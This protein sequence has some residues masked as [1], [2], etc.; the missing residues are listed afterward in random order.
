MSAEDVTPLVM[1]SPTPD[2]GW[3]ADDILHAISYENA[4]QIL[5]FARLDRSSAIKT[6]S[7]AR[8]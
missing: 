6:Q 7:I 1:R 2:E 4:R 3:E 8:K 5:A